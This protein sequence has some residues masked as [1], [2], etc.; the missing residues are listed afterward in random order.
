LK[1][2]AEDF[3]IQLDDVAAAFERGLII[4]AL[5]QADGVQVRAAELL[6]INERS[7][8]HR[9]KK[10]DIAVSKTVGPRSQGSP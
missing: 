8:W 4:E 3:P 9:L 7:L 5:K 2:A 10:H 1:G 6:G